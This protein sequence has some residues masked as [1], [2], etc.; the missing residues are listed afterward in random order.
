MLERK[1]RDREREREYGSKLCLGAVPLTA[2]QTIT[3]LAY[4]TTV[5]QFR[6]LFAT[7]WTDTDQ[8][9]KGLSW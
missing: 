8:A 9:E 6:I 1:K 5:D 4:Q 7:I 3:V 2:M